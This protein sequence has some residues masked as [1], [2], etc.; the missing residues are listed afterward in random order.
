MSKKKWENRQECQVVS[1]CILKCVPEN[2][3]MGLQKFLIFSDLLVAKENCDKSHTVME[4]E[5]LLHLFHQCWN[6]RSSKPTENCCTC[7][8]GV[9][10]AFITQKVVS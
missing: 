7:L 3:P 1:F 9:E 8:L 10:K 5:L 4:Q 2:V 6:R